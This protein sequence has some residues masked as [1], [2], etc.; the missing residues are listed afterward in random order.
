MIFRFF[1]PIS[2]YFE[3][4]AYRNTALSAKYEH[5]GIFWSNILFSPKKFSIL[6]RAGFNYAKAR[7][8]ITVRVRT[9]THCFLSVA[10]TQSHG[11]PCELTFNI[12]F[13]CILVKHQMHPGEGDGR[14]RDCD[15]TVSM[16]EYPLYLG[17]VAQ[18]KFRPGRYITHI[19]SPIFEEKNRN[20]SLARFTAERA[21]GAHSEPK[22]TTEQGHSL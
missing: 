6:Y 20:L 21:L 7:A 13:V 14:C 19:L 10:V 4:T 16:V 18:R 17:A 1:I 2:H 11:A 8:C 3:N 5:I 15:S 22:I 9:G 12:V